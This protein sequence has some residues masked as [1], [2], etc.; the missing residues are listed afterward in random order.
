LLKFIPDGYE[1]YDAH[2]KEMVKDLYGKISDTKYFIDKTPRY[3][4]I[5]EELYEIFPDAKYIYLFRNPLSIFTS[6]L[7]TWC[8]DRLYKLFYFLRDLTVGWNKLGT[9]YQRHHESSI[10]INYESLVCPPEEEVKRICDHLGLEYE[11][12]MIKSFSKV[13]LG[14]SMGDTSSKQ[15]ITKDSLSKWREYMHNPVRRVIYI[16]MFLNRLN[17]LESMGYNKSTIVQEINALHKVWFQNPF[18]TVLKSLV[19]LL[20]FVFLM[21]IVWFKLY[22]FFE[23]HYVKYRDKVVA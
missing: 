9:S 1:V 17:N 19:D 13:V 4:E 11:S 2:V 15:S 18:S 10:K 7:R 6:V 22:F 8:D 16:N 5:I 14:G 20:D 3:H 21:A 23:E 12:S